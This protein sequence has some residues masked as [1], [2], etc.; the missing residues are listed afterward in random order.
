MY[1]PACVNLNEY[2]SP[3]CN[4]VLWNEPSSAAIICGALSLLVRDI[5]P[6]AVISVDAG[7]NWKLAILTL[8]EFTTGFG[9]GAGVGVGVG[10]I[11]LHQ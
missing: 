1:V 8:L 7:E 5:L 9:A 10:V 4:V 11:V 2:L 6:P 3:C